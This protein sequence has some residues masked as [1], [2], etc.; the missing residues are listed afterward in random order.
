MDQ[1]SVQ[2]SPVSPETNPTNDIPSSPKSKLPLVFMGLILLILFSL[3]GIL[4]GKYLYTPKNVV[5]T[6]TIAPE[7]TV[8]PTTTSDATADWKTFTGV[9]WSFKYPSNLFAKETTKNFV[10]L[11]DTENT[12]GSNARVS[13]DARLV[14]PYLDNYDTALNRRVTDLNIINPVTTT[15]S[16]G[17][18]ISGKLGPGMGEGLQVTNGLIKY[19]NGAISIQYNDDN[20]DSQ[21]FTQILSTFKFTDQTTDWKTY[22]S[23]EI[24][25]YV[26]PFQLSYPP[27]WTINQ[28]LTSEEPKSLTLTLTNLNNE[29][30]KILQGMGGGGTCVYYNDSDYTSFDGMGQYFSSYNQLNT[31]ALWRISQFKDKNETSHVVC[32]KTKERYIDGTRIGWISVNI[33]SETSMQEVK[34]ILE[35][36]VFK[37]T[38]KTKTLFD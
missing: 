16:N 25:D 7:Q 27:T 23:P 30:I 8:I 5:P 12:P 22:N 6:P 32:E 19:K 34:S 13:I 38:S 26:S 1:V 36:I 35:K 3:G 14:A 11:V 17:V 37:P 21:T 31:P 10:D 2:P 18:I 20:I 28:K 29:T 4:L 9:D 33:K 24:G 15:L